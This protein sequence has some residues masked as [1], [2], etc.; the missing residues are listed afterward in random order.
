MQ[1]RQW[2]THLLQV[3]LITATMLFTV[4][5]RFTFEP[6]KMHSVQLLHLCCTSESLTISLLTFGIVYIGYHFSSGCS[7]RSV[8]WSTSASIKQLHHIWLRCALPSRQ[9]TTDVTSAL[10][11]TATWQFHESDWQ[12]TQEEVSLCLVCCCG[13]HHHWLSPITGW[14]DKASYGNAGQITLGQPASATLAYIHCSRLVYSLR[15]W[16]LLDLRQS[17]S[18]FSRSTPAAKY[19]VLRIL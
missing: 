10:Q 12:D 7:I 6:C 11:H 9:P 18:N 17:I 8:Y 19:E 3:E 16:C 1:R 15:A 2:C 5:V 14:L 4:Q 13:T